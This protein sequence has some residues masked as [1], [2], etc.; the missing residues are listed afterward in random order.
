MRKAGVSQPT[1]PHAFRH[2]FAT[3]ML[4]HGQSMKTIADLL[5]H[6][7]INSTF[8]YTKVDFQAL[9]QLPLDWPEV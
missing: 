3:R 1:G 8:I 9:V 2:G 7:N 6:R 5:G 4:R